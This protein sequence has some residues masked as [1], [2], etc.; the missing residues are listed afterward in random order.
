MPESETTAT[1]TYLSCEQAGA[2]LN[3]SPR[4]LEKLRT[5]GGGPRFRKLGRRVLYKLADLDAWSDARACESTS[6]PAYT[7]LHD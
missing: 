7:T 3:L 1:T 5:V 2:H 4:T 6:D